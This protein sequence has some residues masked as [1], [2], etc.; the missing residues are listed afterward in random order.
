MTAPTR[1]TTYDVDPLILG[2]WSP[3][4]FD[5]SS[6]TEEQALTL[7]DAA[8]WAPSA[9]N[10]QPWRFLYAQRDDAVWGEFLDLLVPFNAAWAK[11][12]AAL[13]FVLSDTLF[14]PDDGKDARAATTNSFDAG[15]A[16]AFLALQA[17]RLGLHSHAMAGFDEEKARGYFDLPPRYRIEAAVAVG[18]I[19]DKSRLPEPLQAR[20]FPSNRLPLDVLAFRDYLPDDF[21]G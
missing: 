2:R 16:W 11:E 14:A 19:A 8:R 10:Y 4:A 18:R 13:I 6:I 1:S 20:E 12:A 3:R 15:A 21:A 5:G 9:Y 7:F 17:S